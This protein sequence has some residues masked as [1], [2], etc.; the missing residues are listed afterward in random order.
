MNLYPPAGRTCVRALAI[1]VVSIFV[2]GIA[3]QL[4]I[5]RAAGPFTVNSLADTPDASPGDGTCADTNGACTLRAAIEES[6][7][8]PGDDTNNFSVNGTSNRTSARPPR[9][10]NI[11]INGPGSALLT[12]RRDTGGNYRI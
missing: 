1:L 8:S 11:T 5:T 10:T 4:L 3:S 7:H 9:F 2:I 12:V 6:N